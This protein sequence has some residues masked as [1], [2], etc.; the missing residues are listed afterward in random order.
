MDYIGALFALLLF[1]LVLVPKLGLM[2]TSF[3][4]GLLNLFVAG[5]ALREVLKYN[6]VGLEQL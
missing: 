3:L 2:Q 4:F 1:P 5:M 6:D